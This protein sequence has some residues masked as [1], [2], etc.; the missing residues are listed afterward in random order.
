M[1]LAFVSIV[2]VSIIVISIPISEAYG[3][4]I[5]DFIKLVRALVD[6]QN[7]KQQIGYSISV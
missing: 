2:T 1:I 5:V 3:C 7:G 4:V 6:C